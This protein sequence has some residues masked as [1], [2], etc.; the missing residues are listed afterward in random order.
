MDNK[1]QVQ[2]FLSHI[3]EE[4]E[5][6]LKLKSLIELHFLNMVNVFVSSDLSSNETGEKWLNNITSAL[7]VCVMG[8]ILSSNNSIMRPWINFEAGAL[9]VRDIKVIQACHSGMSKSTLPI[10]LNQLNGIDI[11]SKEDLLS[12]FTS[13]SKKLK[14]IPPN[15]DFTDFINFVTGFENKYVLED[16]IHKI[17]NKFINT[18]GVLITNNPSNT[19]SNP[20]PFDN[21]KMTLGNLLKL[22]DYN[23]SIALREADITEI[24]E[25][26]KSIDKSL[27]RF[28]PYTGSQINL[29]SPTNSQLGNGAFY[30][31]SFTFA[32]RIQNL[33]TDN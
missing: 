27:M 28:N 17:F 1:N 5:I 8:I 7:K 25:L 18:D 6:A 3:H 9:W 32:P 2:V 23:T 24:K 10:P 16:K 30:S 11:T 15:P 19:H 33:F 21:L 26:S 20:K 29:S 31:C 4:K 12:L 14:S 13:I 22:K